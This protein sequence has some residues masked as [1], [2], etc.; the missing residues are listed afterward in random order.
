[1]QKK[2]MKTALFGFSKTDVC[3][4]IVKINTEYNE[5]IDEMNAEYTA[6]KENLLA[7]I[8]SLT[9]ENEKY[10]Q[11]NSDIAQ[12]LC[13]A[14]KYAAE[15]KEK[16]DSEY[17][18][19]VSDLQLLREVETDKLNTYREKIEQARKQ[20][21]F[22]LDDIDRKLEAQTVQAD[23]LVA[24]YGG[25]DLSA[26]YREVEAAPELMAEDLLAGYQSAEGT[27]V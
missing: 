19:A 16:A 24:Q 3:E 21:V 6:E 26:K 9:E 12:A 2:L 23:N 14:Q 11:V 18:T 1:M 13:D 22:L 4:Y 10:K 27:E 20:I 25:E 8:A 5:K 15:L 17:K 7:Q